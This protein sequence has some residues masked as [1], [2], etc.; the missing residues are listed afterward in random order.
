MGVSYAFNPFFFAT[1]STAAAV[2]IER[3]N[4]ERSIDRRLIRW[5]KR[6]STLF[7]LQFPI[8]PLTSD[9]SILEIWNTIDV[10]SNDSEW[11]TGTH[12][13]GTLTKNHITILHIHLFTQTSPLSHFVSLSVNLL[14]LHRKR[15]PY[16]PLPLS[17]YPLDPLHMSDSDRDDIHR[18]QV[19]ELFWRERSNWE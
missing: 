14:H 1:R 10:I 6:E 8:L 18:N 9:I 19:W 7:Y 17:F 5:M 12:E 15:L 11:I 3:A 16:Q 4:P 2:G 13:E